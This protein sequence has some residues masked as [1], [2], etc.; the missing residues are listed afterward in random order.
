MTQYN[1]KQELVDHRLDKQSALGQ[2]ERAIQGLRAISATFWRALMKSPGSCGP[3]WES[4]TAP[5]PGL[6]LGLSRLLCEG[7]SS[8]EEASVIF[9]PQT[10][11]KWWLSLWGLSF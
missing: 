9:H 6:Y 1:L 5:T 2:K 3:C 11:N 4:V 10:L 7:L 8:K